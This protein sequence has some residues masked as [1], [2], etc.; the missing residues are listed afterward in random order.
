MLFIDSI[1]CD[2]FMHE[3]AFSF[4]RQFYSWS[5]ADTIVSLQCLTNIPSGSVSCLG[6][7]PKKKH[8]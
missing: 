7:G 4:Y 2:Q 5:L 6:S 8:L 3:E 1:H